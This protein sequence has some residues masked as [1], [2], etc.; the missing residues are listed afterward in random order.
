M[1]RENF[2]DNPFSSS[3]RMIYFGDI[4]NILLMH[5]TRH[6]NFVPPPKKKLATN[7]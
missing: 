1:H 4:D 2:E 7:F 6:D 3:R 5:G